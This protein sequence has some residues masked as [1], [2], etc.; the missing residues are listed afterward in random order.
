MFR[1]TLL[2]A[3]LVHMGLS[4]TDP[5]L[6]SLAKGGHWKRVRA[7]A[8]QRIKVQPSD[9]EGYLYLARAKARF[10]DL[11]GASDASKRAVELAPGSAEAWATHAANLGTQAQRASLLKQMGFAKD[12]RAA[13]EKA[14]ALDGKNRTA[15]EVMAGYYENA[16]GLIG[17]DKEKAKGLR[18]TLKGLDPD[19][20]FVLELNEALKTKEAGRIDAALRK[21]QQGRP[22]ETWPYTNAASIYLDPARTLRPQEGERAARAALALEPIHAGAMGYLAVSLAAQGRWKEVDEVLARTEQHSAENLVPYYSLGRF[23]LL[24]GTDLPRAEACFR[25]YLGQDPEGGAPDRA[26]AHWRLGLVLEK[27]GRKAEAIQQL[28]IALKIN[29]DH[30]D[31]KAD[32]KRL[33]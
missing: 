20:S 5:A 1:V 27:Q 15:L 30:K 28:Q 6:E 32:L 23:L 19:Q 4:A 18:E 21:A 25:R 16:P 10:N 31:A 13:G 9:P 33:G 17:G 14:L 7:Q 8:E 3:L 29:P 11:Q 2:A 24:T 26:S 12:C 22:K